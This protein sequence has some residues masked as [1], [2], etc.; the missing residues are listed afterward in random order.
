MECKEESFHQDYNLIT[1][2][3]RRIDE[4][5]KICEK[6]KETSKQATELFSSLYRSLLALRDNDYFWFSFEN[7]QVKIIKSVV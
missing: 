2:L 3:L 1:S 4:E 5:V 6:Q 7:N